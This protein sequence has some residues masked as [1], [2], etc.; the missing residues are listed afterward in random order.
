M[1]LVMPSRSYAIRV[2]YSGGS[3]PLTRDVGRNPW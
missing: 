1:R 3:V 2:E